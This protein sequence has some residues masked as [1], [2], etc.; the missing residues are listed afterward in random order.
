MGAVYVWGF[1][2]R[3]AAG[4]GEWILFTASTWGWPVGTSNAPATTYSVSDADTV[5]LG[6]IDQDGIH[7]RSAAVEVEASQASGYGAWLA[8]HF[9]AGMLADPDAANTTWGVLAD[10]DADG[11]ANI[12]EFYTATDP[13]DPSSKRL[14]TAGVDETGE[15]LLFT[16]YRAKDTTGAAAVIEWSSDMVHWHTEGVEI[17]E[18][19]ELEDVER[20]VARVPVNAD[21]SFARLNVFR[22]LD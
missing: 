4:P 18:V 15:N 16:F 19:E 12:I 1:D 11:L 20:V 21:E 6:A 14:T 2:N 8:E 10:P 9:S 22:A 3:T 5:I 7:M 13:N 17:A